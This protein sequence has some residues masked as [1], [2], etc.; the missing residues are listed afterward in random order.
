VSPNF[1]TDQTIYASSN[2]G[3]YQSQDSG[4]TWHN[5]LENDDLKHLTWIASV[6]GKGA[7]KTIM[8]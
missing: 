8:E 2:Q 5:I 7:W 4:K 3:I 1:A 6:R